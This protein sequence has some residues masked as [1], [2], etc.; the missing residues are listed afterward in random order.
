MI[1]CNAVMLQP[2]WSF[3]CVIY[4]C[5]MG[6]FFSPTEK[7]LKVF[8]FTTNI[9]YTLTMSNCDCFLWD[10]DRFCL[11]QWNK[12]KMHIKSVSVRGAFGKLN[13]RCKRFHYLLILICILFDCRIY[14]I[15]QSEYYYPEIMVTLLIFWKPE[16][17]CFTI[18][19]V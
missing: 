9:V 19:D 2:Q 6:L 5:S 10:S 12:L 11:Q 13:R 17:I 7:I 3:V 4:S 16:E 15:K 14:I 1:G 8:D 18:S